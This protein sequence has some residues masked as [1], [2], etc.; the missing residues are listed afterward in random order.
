MSLGHVPRWMI[1]FMCE[2]PT[3]HAISGESFGMISLWIDAT[4]ME[5]LL[6]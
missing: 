2:I 5:E 6:I 3:T 1:S 4:E